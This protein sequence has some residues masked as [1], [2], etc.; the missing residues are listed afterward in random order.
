MKELMKIEQPRP[1]SGGSIPAAFGWLKRNRDIAKLAEKLKLNNPLLIEFAYFMQIY[2]NVVCASKYS[3]LAD[4]IEQ[5]IQSEIAQ[6]RLENAYLCA[7]LTR[8]DGSGAILLCADG[9]DSPNLVLIDTENDHAIQCENM[10]DLIGL[11]GEI[12]AIAFEYC[13]IRN[14]PKQYDTFI[15]SHILGEPN[16]PMAVT[17]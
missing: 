12:Y 8:T 13:A 15:L 2:L 10:Q 14:K 11:F 1:A 7:V 16:Q 5:V 17:D 9:A 4:E 6:E 3:L